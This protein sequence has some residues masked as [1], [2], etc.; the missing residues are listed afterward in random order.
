[1]LIFI[2]ISAVLLSKMMLRAGQVT[3]KHCIF[4]ENAERKPSEEQ[5]LELAEDAETGM[6]K[7]KEANNQL[8]ATISKFGTK[9]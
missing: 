4:S 8:K 3:C 7:L 9:S 5:L 1:M 6:L 2:A